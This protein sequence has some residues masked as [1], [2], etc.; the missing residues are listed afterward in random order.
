MEDSEMHHEDEEDKMS[1]EI[2]ITLKP[3]NITTIHKRDV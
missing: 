2:S 3:M 1:N